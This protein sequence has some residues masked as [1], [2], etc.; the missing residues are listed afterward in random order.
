VSLRKRGYKA[1]NFAVFVDIKNVGF[2]CENGI[3][4]AETC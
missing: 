3:R 1:G 4:I 2:H